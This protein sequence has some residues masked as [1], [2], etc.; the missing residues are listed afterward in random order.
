MNSRKV[1]DLNVSQNM[2]LKKLL[3]YSFLKN[4]IIFGRKNILTNIRFALYIQLNS[5]SHNETCT[6]RLLGTAQGFYSNV[7]VS[8]RLQGWPL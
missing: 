5:S 1:S 4:D 2:G 7:L 3:I 8:G 6:V